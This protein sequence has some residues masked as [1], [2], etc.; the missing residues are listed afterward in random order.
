MSG[1]AAKYLVL[2]NAG[3]LIPAMAMSQLQTRFL[4]R[5][6]DP[7]EVIGST[8]SLSSHPFLQPSSNWHLHF[9]A[10]HRWE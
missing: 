6:A 7:L 4:G 2:N 9:T 10:S 8:C 5:V 3:S 1:L